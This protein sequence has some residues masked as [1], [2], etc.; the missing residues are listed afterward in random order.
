[1]EEGARTINLNK[2]GVIYGATGHPFIKNKEDGIG[3]YL[4]I[5]V[6]KD[7]KAYDMGISQN[8]IS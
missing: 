4:N 8:T 3:Q 1:M 6:I 2:R 7:I 5:A